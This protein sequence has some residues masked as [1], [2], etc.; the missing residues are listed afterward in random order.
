MKRAVLLI[1]ISALMLCALPSCAVGGN[2]SVIEINETTHIDTEIF[3]YF[4]DKIYYENQGI[5]EDECIERATSECLK[6]IAVNTRF[7]QMGQ[8]LSAREKADVSSVTNALWRVY[9]DYFTEIGVSKDTFFKIMQY[10]VCKENLQLALYDR[11]G[12]SPLSE[13]YIKQYF[14]ANFVGIKYFYQELYTVI[15][16]AEY[17]ALTEYEKNA[18]DKSKK[19]AEE[20]YK[21]I[22]SV[23]NYVNSSVYTMDEAFM[24]VT[25]EVS[26]DI[27]VSAEVVS[28]TGSSFSED[29]VNAVFKQSVGSAF[30]I[31]NSD[32][33]NVYFIERIDLLDSSYGFY[34]EYRTQCLLA[35]SESFFVSEINNWIQSYTAVRH[36]SVARRCFDAVTGV[37]RSKYAGTENYNFESF[38][39]KNSEDI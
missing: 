20:R 18:Y 26:A 9:G 19:S 25:G 31:T 33:S 2:R 4:L 6:Y 14:T 30:I 37:D 16:D 24:A 17:N 35:V 15:S 28:K 11:N 29:F 34:E 21:F 38:L 10:E 23:A 32:K 22:S 3:T 1:L 8:T 13:E 27:S 12:T 5:S 39:P 36:L 7:A